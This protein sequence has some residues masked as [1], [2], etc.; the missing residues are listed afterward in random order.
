MNRR[1]FLESIIKAG[2]ACAILP[3]ALTY[4]RQWKPTTI[5]TPIVLFDPKNYMGNWMWIPN[6]EWE[7]AEYEECFMVNGSFDPIHCIHY[8]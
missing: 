8:S 5:A 3:S 7:N 2:A 6:P 4:A 1:G